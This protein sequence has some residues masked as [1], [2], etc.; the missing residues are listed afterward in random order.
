MS[1]RSAKTRSALATLLA[2]LLSAC[3]MGRADAVP[4]QVERFGELELVTHSRTQ[5]GGDASGFARIQVSHWSLRWQGQ[6]LVFDTL[7][8]LFGDQPRR[9]TVAHAVFV[10]GAEAEAP[11]FVDLIALVGDPNNTAAFHRVRLREGRLVTSLL[12]IASGGSNSVAWTQHPSAKAPAGDSAWRHGPRRETMT[13]PESPADAPPAGEGAVRHLLRL[14]DRCLFDPADGQVGLTPLPPEQVQP[15][16]AWGPALLS[17][18]GRQLLRLGLVDSRPV[19]TVAPLQRLPEGVI[20]GSVEAWN[21]QRAQTPAWQLLPIDRS[22]MRVSRPEAIDAAWVMHHFAW[23]ADADA[24]SWAL[25]E[26]AG[27]QPLPHRGWYLSGHDQYSLD[28]LKPGAAAR[29]AQWMAT[30]LGG[31]VFEVEPVPGL[32]DSHLRMEIDGI[33]VQVMDGFYISAPLNVPTNHPAADP[34]RRSALIRR[35]GEA[36]DAELATGAL[37]DLFD[38]GMEAGLDQAPGQGF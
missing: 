6:P 21:L 34:Q 24:G 28:G 33:T 11:A 38:F 13:V 17:P 25:A 26:R 29:L 32:P 18:D 2:G 23:V 16:D 12:C 10:L 1:P 8:G 27:F 7:G 5:R 20:P 19:V 31:R 37:D 14:G 3:G 30:R 4:D 15:L 35:L 9:L 36:V 22:R